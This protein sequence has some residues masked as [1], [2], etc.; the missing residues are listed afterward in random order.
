MNWREMFI[1]D[2]IEAESV[3]GVEDSLHRQRM[4]Y[5][6]SLRELRARDHRTGLH[7]QPIVGCPLCE[8]R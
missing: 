7:P 6:Q 4:Q 8:L 3:R 5:E 1:M 2:D